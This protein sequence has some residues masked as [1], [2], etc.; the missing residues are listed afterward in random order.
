MND[1]ERCLRRKWRAISDRCKH[2]KYYKGRVFNQFEDYSEFK[3]WS[4]MNG[5]RRGFVIHRKDR[6]GHYNKDNCEYISEADHR[7]ITGQERRRFSR[8]TIIEIRNIYTKG[9]SSIALGLEYGYS[10]RGI[11][12]IVNL[13]T[14]KDV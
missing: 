4:L 12:Q 13:E 14:Y 5:W 10:Q 7:R 9:K 8:E 1:I 11:I 6:N 2:N 3:K